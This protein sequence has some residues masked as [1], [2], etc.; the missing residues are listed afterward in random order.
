MSR[1]ITAILKDASEPRRRRPTR[2][3]YERPD[4]RRF[5]TLRGCEQPMVGYII[6][7][8]RL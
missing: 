1:R 5:P 8:T 3:H 4:L 2:I 6:H 7:R